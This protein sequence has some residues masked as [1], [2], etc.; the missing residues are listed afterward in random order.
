M[1]STP[2]SREELTVR[3]VNI[4]SVTASPQEND[5]AVFVYE[6]LSKLD[7]FKKNPSHLEMV[8]TPLEGD[9]RP[10]H[11]VAARMMAE[12]PTKKTAVFIGHYDVVEVGV[13]GELEPWAFDPAELARRFA[14]ED[15][16]GRARE[17]FLSGGYL[18]G[19][20]TM[21]MKCGLALEMELLRDY[22]ADPGLFDLNIIVLAVPDEEN[23]NCGMRGA[24]KYLAALKKAEGLVY[25]AGLNTEP[26]DPGLP[27]AKN[28]LI[29]M[30]GLGKLLPTFYCAGLEAHVGNYYR[31]LSATLLSSQIVCA[32]EAA[33]ELADPH[34]GKCQ[35]SWICLCH[36]TLAEGYFVTVP[37]RSVAY[38]NAFLTTKAPA[39]VMDEMR[40]IAYRA[41][42]AAKGQLKRS[43]DALSK[44]GYEPPMRDHGDA[45]VISF[46][47]IYDM[48]AARYAGG[49]EALSAHVRGFLKKLPEGDMRDRGVAALEE[50]IRIAE[51]AAPFVAVGFLPPY[52][53]AITSLS[54]K[55]RANVVVR[56]AE[57][58]VAEARERYGVAIDIAEFF[59]GLCD[60]S[61]MGF[62]GTREDL[63]PIAK[64][65][66]GW[67]ELYSVP[68]DE[69][70]EIDMPVMNMGPCGYDAHRKAERLER[71][72]SFEILPELIVFMVRALSEEW[73]RYEAAEGGR[74]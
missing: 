40:T 42:E 30:G 24:A 26:S 72:Y 37:S 48:A 19:R 73:E 65:C 57:R 45:R 46:G 51:V 23:T 44:M 32:A 15:L 8:P 12:V 29:F 2:Q 9:S 5:A 11:T 22:D 41:I 53:P 49:A 60:L 3:L 43:H 55:P 47:E 36:K 69:L 17:D 68:V 21:D 61:Y 59:A 67:G 71:K 74:L 33:P 35:P 63:A 70:I 14:P 6:H 66:P 13:Y 34:H 50:L 52:L 18:F 10:L 38:F 20:G 28:Q 56:T 64:N 58:V 31:G 4:P 25:I 7:Y 1:I 62:G 16:E 54:G 39:A 27:D